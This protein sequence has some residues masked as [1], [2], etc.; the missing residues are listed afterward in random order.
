[1][2]KLPETKS[3]EMN[4]PPNTEIVDGCIIPTAPETN[5]KFIVIDVSKKDLDERS[6]RMNEI[7]DAI[8]HQDLIY[9]ISI[10]DSDDSIK[11]LKNRLVSRQLSQM[12]VVNDLTD[13]F[14]RSI[15]RLKTFFPLLNIV[16]RSFYDLQMYDEHG[17]LNLSKFLEKNSATCASYNLSYFSL[18]KMESYLRKTG[19]S[20]R[21]NQITDSIEFEGF[22][23]SKDPG[24]INL[25][26]S[27]LLD[28]LKL[29]SIKTDESTVTHHLKIIARK[30]KYNPVIE[31]LE[32]NKWDGKDRLEMIY[33]ILGIKEDLD[34]TLVKK[35]LMQCV[36]LAYNDGSY[37]ADGV[38]TFKGGQGIGKTS[39]F[40]NL[41]PCNEWFCDGVSINMD[42]KDSL[43]KPLKFWI[44]ELGELDS[45]TRREQSSLK[46]FITSPKD[47]IRKPYAVSE[48][49]T[50]RHC[51]MC[52]TV[53][54]EDFLRDQTG[55]RRWWTIHTASIDLSRM[56]ELKD[57]RI[58]L[59]SQIHEL[60][61]QD[62]Q[63][64]RLSF[65]EQKALAEQNIPYTS[66]LPYIQQFEDIFDWNAAKSS[67]RLHTAT[68]LA[69]MVGAKGDKEMQKFFKSLKIY[70]LKNKVEVK[71]QHNKK[72]FL[73]PPV[74]KD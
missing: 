61:K 11:E 57:N 46:S 29:K 7:L 42:N 1:M 22:T 38:L 51:S 18:S 47:S 72:L 31:M 28:E 52:A 43:M 58:Q 12:Y 50:P 62:R 74:S 5:A 53:N 27:M 24:D 39:F 15:K 55:N 13:E 64:F 10:Y 70:S 34:K 68:E 44:I 23:E 71:I 33:E 4:R 9:L 40:M 63:G 30:N 16:D 32:Q 25:I 26:P 36:A 35:W 14:D 8:G 56:Q 59:W 2:A 6:K 17:A 48:E 73:V 67:W 19:R 66:N 37:G 41:I 60:W 3:E 21:Y 65:Q 54:D 20:I 49:T 69:E 45:T